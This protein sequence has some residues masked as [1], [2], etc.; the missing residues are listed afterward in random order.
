[1]QV[2]PPPTLRTCTRRKILSLVVNMINR[3][4][5]VVPKK[6]RSTSCEI[7]AAPSRFF[8]AAP[9]IPASRHIWCS[10]LLTI[11][12][13]L[14]IDLLWICLTSTYPHDL[15]WY[16]HILTMDM[17]T[18]GSCLCHFDDGV[19]RQEQDNLT[20][21][22]DLCQKKLERVWSPRDRSLLF[23]SILLPCF[24]RCWCTWTH[25]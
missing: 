8:C 7:G 12:I 23:F 11:F 1:M 22:V 4:A 3:T 20:M 13:H 6:Y 19:S 18:V 24:H 21:E 2:N 25:F 16:W 15:H 9:D 14:H 10:V 5:G 17:L